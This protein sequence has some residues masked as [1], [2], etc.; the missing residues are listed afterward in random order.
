[1]TEVR[2]LGKGIRA[3]IPETGSSSTLTGEVLRIPLESIRLNPYQPR[4]Q[5]EE[6][7]IQELANSIRESGLIYPLLVRKSMKSG[8]DRPVYELIAGERRIRALR[9]LGEKEAPVIL[10]EVSDQ[11]AL[12]LALIENLQRE[13][14]NPMEQASAYQRLISEFGLTQEQV[15]SAVGKDRATVANTVRLLKLAPLVQEEVARGRLTLGHARALLA[16]E[17]H[18]AQ[19]ELAQKAVSGGLSVRQVERAV[20][21]TNQ[22]PVQGRAAKQR[23]PHLAAVEQKLQKTLGT[24]VQIFHGR[25]RGWIRIA[26]YSLKDL[27]RLIGRLT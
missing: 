18:R 19:Q 3:L 23:D 22:R 2:G 12:E 5:I 17:S 24:N 7:K 4:K 16:L 20:Q 27:D 9:Q 8:S 11:D 25:T 1:M 14:L 26:Y 13:E 10:K 21:E 6:S 15:A